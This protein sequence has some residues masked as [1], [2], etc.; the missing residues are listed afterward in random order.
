MIQKSIGVLRNIIKQRKEIVNLVKQI[1]T[2]D[3]VIT[4]VNKNN[5]LNILGHTESDAMNVY[6]LGTAIALSYKKALQDNPDMPLHDYMQQFI[7]VAM[8]HIERSN[9]E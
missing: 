6:M 9:N 1:A 4:I 5:V 3:D 8:R 2:A 7:I